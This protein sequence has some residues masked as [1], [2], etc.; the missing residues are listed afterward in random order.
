M[1]RG[2]CV[3][4]KAHVCGQLAQG[5]YAKIKTA[6]VDDRELMIIRNRFISWHQIL[7]QTYLT[8]LDDDNSFCCPYLAVKSKKLCHLEAKS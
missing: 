2:G 7:K 1:L 8:C 3:V 5:R 6:E 4:T